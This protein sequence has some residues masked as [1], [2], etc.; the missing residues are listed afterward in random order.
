M[1]ERIAAVASIAI[2]HVGA[3]T[4]LILSD[5]ETASLVARR[6]ATALG[7]MVGGLLLAVVVACTWLIAA[8]W[9]TPARDWVL[10]GLLA[11]F[12]VVSIAAFQALR[13]INL[14]APTM[15]SRTAR[16]WAKDRQ[17]LEEL[18]ER[19]RRALP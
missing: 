19:E 4:D 7:V 5:V 11:L 2:R 12:I 1:M 8:V 14:G 16:E 13:A 6:R 15:L 10:G 18:L 3:Y 17:L 9:D